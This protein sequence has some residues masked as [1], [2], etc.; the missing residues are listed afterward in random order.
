[1]FVQTV[2]LWLQQ[3][4]MALPGLL[5]RLLAAWLV[6]FVVLVYTFKAVKKRVRR[7]VLQT[8]DAVRAWAKGLRYRTSSLA[9]RHALTWFFR[10][11]TNFA[12]AP[13]LCIFSLALPLFMYV[14]AAQ[15]YGMHN[16][17]EL[18]AST[19][20]WLLPGLCYAGSMVLSYVVKRVF[21]RLRPPRPSGSFGHKL[22]DGSFPSGHSL[23]VLCFWSMVIVTLAQAGAAP[24]SVLASGL[25][26]AT[27]V[28]LTGLSRVYLAVHFPSDVAGG[29]IIGTVWNIVAYLALRGAL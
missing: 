18:F 16:A 23:T 19:R 11:W 1:M 9:E 2:G 13:S 4:L 10:F 14:R 3:F 7:R 27:V 21:K 8:D 15:S 12:S 5:P 20:I 22:K 28:F 26:A 17:P 25:M 6:A 29:F 24:L